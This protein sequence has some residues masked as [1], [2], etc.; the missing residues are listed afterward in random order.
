MRITSIT[1]TSCLV[2]AA[3]HGGITAFSDQTATRGISVTQDHSVSPYP[4]QGDLFAGGSVG[5]FNGDGWMDIFVVTGGA[6]PDRLYLNDGNGFFTDHA[7]AWGLTDRHY[8]SGASV[9]DYDNDGDLDIY[10][11]SIGVPGVGLDTGRHR[12]YRNDGGTFTNVAAAAGVSASSVLIGDG[13]GSAFGDYDLDGDLDLAVAGWLPNISGNKLFRNNGDGT[14]TD[15]TA[16]LE[17]DLNAVRGFSPRFTDMDGDRYPELLFVSDFG[18]S[19]YFINDGDGTFTEFTQQAGVGIDQFG[20]G[21]TIGDFNEDGLPD[22]YVTS[23]HS[24]TTDPDRFGNTLYLNQGN[25]SYIEVAAAWNV[26]DGGWGWGTVA[27]DINHDTHIDLVE[28]NGWPS[29]E[30][31]GERSRLW[32]NND[33]GTFTDVAATAGLSHTTQG[34]GMANLDI[35]NDGDQ[36]IIIFTNNGSPQLFRN[37]LTGSD[38]HW[39]RVFLNTSAE[40]DLAP[41]GFGSTVR[42]LADGN[43]QFRIIDGGCNYLAVSELSAHFGLAEADVVAELIVEWNNGRRTLRRNVAA[44]QTL[45]ITSCFIDGDVDGDERVDFVDLNVILDNWG[46]AVP[47]YRNGDANGDGAVNFTDLDALLSGWGTTCQ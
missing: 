23:I 30:W 11:T 22:W 8:G 43:P 28:T 36:D 6:E 45:T 27:V 35:E 21:T 16:S 38:T 32:I 2:A 31:I 42:I 13:L 33:D 7:A 29:E 24:V 25:H 1:I 10:V 18:T 17:F 47:V 3:C 20:M 9:G 34:R 4:F 44:D 26:D 14:F 15:A 5:D 41:D 12:L 46:T 19:K 39:L 40:A 37:D